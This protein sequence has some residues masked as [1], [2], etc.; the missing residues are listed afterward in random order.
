MDCINSYGRARKYFLEK[1]VPERNRV[2]QV[3]KNLKDEIQKETI[4][5][6]I[7]SMAYSATGALSGGAMLISLL[8]APMTGGMSSLMALGFYGGMVSGVADIA[9]RGIKWGIVVN[10]VDNAET[11]LKNHEITYSN[12]KQDYLL[13][14][15]EDIE[16]IRNKI[17]IIRQI[18]CDEEKEIKAILK[19]LLDIGMLN[20]I[21]NDSQKFYNF[22]LEKGEFVIDLL[23]SDGLFCRGLSVGAKLLA[24][25]GAKQLTEE[26]VKEGAK[27]GAKN[28]AKQVA[29]RGI[30]LGTRDFAKKGA[31]QASKQ[32]AKEGAKGFVKAFSVASVGVGLVLDIKSLVSS[33]KDLSRLQNGNM[34]DEADKMNS[35]IKQMETELEYL[36]KWFEERSNEEDDD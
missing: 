32:A 19:H 28:G 13:K 14:L 18:K 22:L 8:A 31:K 35:V 9:H 25:Q 23:V 27:K 21:P 12:L 26:A 7:G 34:C 29:K 10:L 30:K 6:K 20:N 5:Q 16:A 3:L 2:I 36:D 33:Q 1:F 11:T 15:I 24:K 4:N 17:E